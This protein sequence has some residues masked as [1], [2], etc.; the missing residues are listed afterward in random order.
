VATARQRSRRSSD[1]RLI[2]F[3]VFLV[4]AAG[5]LILVGILASIR[6]GDAPECSR[7]AIGPADSIREDL[8][9]G[10]E[11][12]TGGGGCSF[13]LSL[14]GGD[15]VAYSTRIDERDC[16]VTYRDAAYFC[17]GQQVGTDELTQYPT[18]IETID[19][20]DALIVDLRPPADRTDGPSTTA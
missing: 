13:F 20:I 15:I 18:A 3:S 12:R 16:T 11:F 8:A 1:I 19:G 2:V 5:G 7:L 17:D 10:P 9:A 14:D 4:L 6:G